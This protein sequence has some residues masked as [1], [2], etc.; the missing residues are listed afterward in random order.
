MSLLVIKEANMFNGKYTCHVNINSTY[1]IKSYGWI[2]VKLPL[3][4][5][6]YNEFDL[7]KLANYYNVPFIFDENDLTTFGKRVGIGGG[8]HT[9]CKS[10]ESLYSISFIWIHLRNNT[11]QGIKTIEFVQHDGDRIFIE[12]NEY[13]SNIF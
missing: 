8:F 2:D 6:M 3:K 5:G 7:G 13:S 12:E 4:N 9:E 11:S 10:V 1:E